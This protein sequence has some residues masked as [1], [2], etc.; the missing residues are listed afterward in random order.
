MPYKNPHFLQRTL[1]LENK[2]KPEDKNLFILEFCENNNLE[3]FLIE[4][5][6]PSLELFK[7]D[8]EGHLDRT[9]NFRVVDL[10]DSKNTKT[11]KEWIDSKVSLFDDFFNI[12]NGRSYK[13]DIIFRNETFRVF[14]NG[15]SVHLRDF[16]FLGDEVFEL[17]LEW[18]CF[19]IDYLI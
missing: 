17:K 9:I 15:A 1:L 6:K 19:N 2:V 5:D 18:D 10:I 7:G 4:L 11:L 3:S 16:N 14:L 12:Q 8:I 13:K